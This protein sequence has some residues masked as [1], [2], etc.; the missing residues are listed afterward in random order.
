MGGDGATGF[1]GLGVPNHKFRLGFNYTPQ[2]GLRG[3]L[4]FQ[5]DDSFFANL[6]QFTGDTG[7][8]NLFDGAIG[9]K[10]INGL[11]ID[12]TAQNLFDNEY[13]VFALFP[14]IGRRVLAKVT[15]T[16]GTDKE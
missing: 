13:R 3:N 14:K 12:V 10:F 8:R 16:F 9:Y 7:A 6:G 2:S 11:S 15:Y 4:S 5:H 1:T